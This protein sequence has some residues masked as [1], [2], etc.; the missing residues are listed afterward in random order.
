MSFNFMPIGAA[1]VSMIG[2]GVQVLVKTLAILVV[3]LVRI[4]F[5]WRMDSVWNPPKFALS[6]MTH[7]ERGKR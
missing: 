5:V 2:I 7:G 3:N 1:K 6:A 4:E